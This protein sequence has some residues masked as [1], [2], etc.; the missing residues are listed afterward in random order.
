MVIGFFDNY[1][2][3]FEENPNSP[4]R[5][6]VGVRGYTILEA[7]LQIRFTPRPRNASGKKCLCNEFVN[8]CTHNKHCVLVCILEEFLV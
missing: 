8:E 6:A 4:C 2:D 3:G 1:Y 7:P 5:V